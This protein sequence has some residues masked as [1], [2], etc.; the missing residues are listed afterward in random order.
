[1]FSIMEVQKLDKE[2]DDIFCK[3]PHP[4]LLSRDGRRFFNTKIEY[5]K[6]YKRR[7]KAKW[8]KGANQILERYYREM[9]GQSRKFISYFAPD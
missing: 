9:S 5:V 3:I 7:N 1:M 6:R 8:I 2:I 4:R